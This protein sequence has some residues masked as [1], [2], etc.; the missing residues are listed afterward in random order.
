MINL[1][2]TMTTFADTH[3]ASIVHDCRNVFSCSPENRPDLPLY[4]YARFIFSQEYLQKV[5]T[6]LAINIYTAVHNPI[7]LH[8]RTSLCSGI[9]NNVDLRG[10]MQMI[11][12]PIIAL[13][14]SHSELIQPLHA[15]TF[16]LGRDQCSTI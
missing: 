12:A 2:V 11:R 14:G 5:S 15:E 4:F 3:F 1:R 16:L 9:L 6:P 7:T 13:H 10:I 8:G